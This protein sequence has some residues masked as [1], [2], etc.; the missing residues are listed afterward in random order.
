MSRIKKLV[1]NL[2]IIGSI[3]IFLFEIS[4]RFSV[5]DFYKTEF[6]ALNKEIAT[7]SVDYLVFG[8][9]FSAFPN[10]Y[11]NYLNQ[12]T[13]KTFVNAAVP[14]I[15]PNQVNTFANRRIKE[16][17]PKAIIYQVYVGN[18]L[19][20]VEHLTNYKT[21]SFSRNVYWDVSDYLLSI[22]YFNY[23]FASYYSNKLAL[24]KEAIGQPFSAAYYNKRSKL[25]FKAN[26]N[27]LYETVTVTGDLE[28]RYAS[29]ITSMKK[30]MDKVPVNIPV[31]I[32]FIPHCSQVND[33]Y[34]NRMEVIGANFK[35][36]KEYK[37]VNYP[38]FVKASADLKMY[39][40]IRFL[41]P[42]SKIKAK[43][44]MSKPLY[45]NNDPHFKEFGHTVL[46]EFIKEELLIKE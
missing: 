9:S 4:Y 18:D 42:L 21:L 33:R 40:N 30:F 17:A 7:D 26:A 23:R 35:D 8:D 34:L 43:D 2:V 19:I 32:I 29:W 14:G 45:Y 24:E 28:D 15:G 37:N 5:I 6:T 39:K 13:N 22:S 44:S 10:G 12:T 20:D 3:T 25:L 31:S 46:G 11:I 38:L 36:A 41:N 1:L 27:Y 16:F